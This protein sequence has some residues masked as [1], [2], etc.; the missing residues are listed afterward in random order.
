MT[1]RTIPLDDP[2]DTQMMG[3]VHSALRRDLV[4]IGM[5]L[6]TSQ[7]VEPARRSALAHHLLWMMR[8][9]HEHHSGED[10]GLYPLVKRRNPASAELVER[11]G[12]DHLTISPAI[13]ALTAAANRH[14]ADPTS[15]DSALQLAVDRLATVLLPHLHREEQ[16]MM[17]MVSASITETSNVPLARSSRGMSAHPIKRA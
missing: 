7:A 16:E 4:R 8:F 1:R 3:I 15:P 11:M 6:G 17:P 14:L 10:D 9:L 13:H 2:A 5:V 12:T